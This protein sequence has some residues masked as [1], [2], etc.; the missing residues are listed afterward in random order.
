MFAGQHASAEILS[1]DLEGLLRAVDDGDVA[2]AADLSHS[3]KGSSRTVGALR[4]GDLCERVESLARSG[5]LA[6]ARPLLFHL[7][8]ALFDVTRELERIST[9][10]RSERHL[11]LH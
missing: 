6:E 5:S 10:R 9:A 4:V 11:D 3:L 1:L 2:G 7:D 8:L